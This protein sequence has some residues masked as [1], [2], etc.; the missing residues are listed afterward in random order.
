MVIYGLVVAI[1]CVLLFYISGSILVWL[2]RPKIE[3]KVFYDT[4]LRLVIGFLF[5]VF[6]IS[7]LKTSGKT[8]HLS[9][10]IVGFIYFYLERKNISIN[11]FLD[12]SKIFQLR[13]NLTPVL[14]VLIFVTIIYSFYATCYFNKPF[15]NILHYDDVFYTFLSSKMWLFGTES[16]FPSFGEN[17]IIN[18]APYHYAEL[19]VTSLISNFFNLNPMLTHSVVLKSSFTAILMVGMLALTKLFTNKK[20]YYLF[21]FSSVF[22]A[23]L[24]LDYTHITQKGSN[25]FPLK[26]I[27]VSFLFVWFAFLAKI[28]SRHWFLPLLVL[29]ILNIAYSIIVFSTL[30]IISI[31]DFVKDKSFKKLLDIQLSLFAITLFF[32]VYYSFQ[33]V[34][35]D[36]NETPMASFTDY[37]VF[38]YFIADTVNHIKNILMYSIYFFPLGLLVIYLFFKRNNQLKRL[39]LENNVLFLYLLISFIIGNVVQFIIYPL[40][41]PN[42]GQMNQINYIVPLNIAV[43]LSFLIVEQYSQLNEKIIKNSFYMFL[44]LVALYNVSIFI[45]SVNNTKCNPADWK[46][47]KYISNINS[48][49]EKG[50]FNNKGARILSNKESWALDISK[51]RG[52]LRNGY[53][54]IPYST[55]MDFLYITNIN[56]IDSIQDDKDILLKKPFDRDELFLNSKTKKCLSKEP[57][58]IFKKKYEDN[59]GPKSLAKIQFEFVKKHNISFIAISKEMQLPDVFKKY[60]DTIFI[61]DKTKEQFVFLN[62]LE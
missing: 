45:I 36:V 51:S 12:Y 39:Y 19:W 30:F 46:G 24:L 8:I 37:Y 54:F 26:I 29:P 20:I 53:W 1:L 9:L 38:K 42:S 4:F 5:T 52:D 47:E 50:C 49:F 33:E 27:A 59:Y 3:E 55:K 7:L 31:V 48:H 56:I 35:E 15:N 13:K 32:I 16:T 22:I 28:K 23:P 58:N 40:A 60:V 44:I 11:Y 18:L 2:L 14:I 34:R 62:S 57:F 10:L 21:A 6:I 43:Y 17:K 25:A 41:G 61:D